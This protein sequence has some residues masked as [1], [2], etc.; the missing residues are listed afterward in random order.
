L[1]Q[2]TQENAS[3][4][5]HTQEV[6]VQT[7]HIALAIVRNADEKRFIGK[8]DVKAKHIHINPNDNKKASSKALPNK[9]KKDSKEKQITPSIE[10]KDDAEWESF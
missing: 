1:D 4:A 9:S 7:Q 3:V 5:T 6:A 10:N 2:Q 8:D